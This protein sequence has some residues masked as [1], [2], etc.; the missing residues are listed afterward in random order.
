MPPQNDLLNRAKMKS[1][2][3]KLGLSQAA[4]AKRAGFQ[5]PQHWSNIERDGTGYAVT[6][7]TLAKIAKALVVK[8]KDLL[9]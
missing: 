2:R 3:L 5:S 9:K 1:H 6:M 8:P 4:A 7:E